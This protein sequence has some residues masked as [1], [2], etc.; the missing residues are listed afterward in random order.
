MIPD[1]LLALLLDEGELEPVDCDDEQENL[2]VTDAADDDTP[3]PDH[4]SPA[5]TPHDS[6]T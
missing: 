6:E 2:Q 1:D 4:Q 3:S 5:S